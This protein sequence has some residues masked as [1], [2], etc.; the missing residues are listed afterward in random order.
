M[1]SRSL[2]LV[3]ARVVLNVLALMSHFFQFEVSDFVLKLDSVLNF[4]FKLL[5][6]LFDSGLEDFSLVIVDGLLPAVP[7]F[8][9]HFFE[10]FFI[11]DFARSDLLAKVQNQQKPLENVK[12]SRRVSSLV[13]LEALPNSERGG[14]V[15][16]VEA[17][18]LNLI[19]YPTV[20]CF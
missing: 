9:T 12:S 20:V 7:E 11:G 14:R 18:F 10:G 8:F 19:E 13:E 3:E 17:Q 1:S 6:E 15:V 16:L 2:N 5:L 4:S